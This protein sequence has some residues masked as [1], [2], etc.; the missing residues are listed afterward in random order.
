MTRFCAAHFAM[1][2]PPA[3]FRRACLPDTHWQLRHEPEWGH[4]CGIQFIQLFYKANYFFHVGLHGLLCSRVK[5]EPG[6]VGQM[7]DE[8][9][10]YSHTSK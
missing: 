5:F 2:L 7:A 10:V 6:K 1:P 9:F 4:A 8:F 3:S